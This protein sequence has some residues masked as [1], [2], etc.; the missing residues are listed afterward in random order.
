VSSATLS[1]SG[2]IAEPTEAP[3]APRLGTIEMIAHCIFHQTPPR[4]RARCD[5]C[6]GELSPINEIWYCGQC[7]HEREVE[8]CPICD[9]RP[10]N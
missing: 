1:I 10:W 2:T 5:E 3:R 7:L 8:D 4:E 6:G 9:G